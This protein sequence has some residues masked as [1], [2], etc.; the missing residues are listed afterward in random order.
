MELDNEELNADRYV[1]GPDST[2]WETD[3]PPVI[4][5]NRLAKAVWPFKEKVDGTK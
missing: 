3:N 5:E 1:L 4:I 2:P